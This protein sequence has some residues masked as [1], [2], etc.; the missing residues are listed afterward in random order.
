MKN[1]L[2]LLPEGDEGEVDGTP[3]TQTL[4]S[5]VGCVNVY[6]RLLQV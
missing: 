5:A 1:M 6:D 4:A 2:G 3:L